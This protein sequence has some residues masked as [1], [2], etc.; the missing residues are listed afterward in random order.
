MSHEANPIL[1]S[2]LVEAFGYALELH[3]RQSRKGTSIPY[4]SHPMGVA[5]LVLEDGGDEDQAIA[6]LLHDGPEDQGGLETLEEIRR[7]FG[8]RVARIVDGCTDTYDNPKPPWRIRKG[9]Y[10]ARLAEEDTD[11]LR[12]SVA[13]KLHNARAILSD[14]RDLGDSLWARFNAG[15]D[16]VMWYF[17][18]LVDIFRRR[19]PGP[20][21]DELA[22]TVDELETLRA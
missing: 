11:T 9:A 1:S 13:D 7:R 20:L 15:P 12:V 21:A 3:R 8:E 16:E 2:R 10:L 6:A 22:R 18:E 17:R 5:S 14:Y 4:L 19:L